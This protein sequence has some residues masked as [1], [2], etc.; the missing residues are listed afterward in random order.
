MAFDFGQTR[1]A[2]WSGAIPQ[3]LE[4]FLI[5]AIQDTSYCL[6]TATQMGGNVMHPLPIPTP[7]D[8]SSALDP[9]KWTMSTARKLAH[10]ALLLLIKRLTSLLD[11][12]HLPTSLLFNHHLGNALSLHL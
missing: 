7:G 4:A 2:P 6:H 1:L 8:D 11:F 9:V 5:E 10:L 3:S 12:R